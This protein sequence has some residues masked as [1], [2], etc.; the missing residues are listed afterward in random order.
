MT[1]TVANKIVI[2]GFGLMGASL[3]AALKQ[4]G[5]CE[6]I[7]AVARSE[8][9][10]RE[11]VAQG[12]AARA[13][14]SIADVAAELTAGDLICLAVP[15]L[16][17]ADILPQLARLVDDSVTLTDC[18]S[19]KGSVAK[20][21]IAAYGEVPPQFVLGH[22]ICGSEKSGVGAANPNLYTHQ[23]II[24]TPLETTAA[25]H[26]ARVRA[27]WQG[28]DSEVLELSV[29]AHDQVL[30]GTSHLPH[31]IAYSLVDTL[32][33]DPD[34]ENLFRYA[35]GGFKDFTRIA[36][37][38]PKMWHDIMLANRDSILRS[39]DLFSENFAVLRDAIAAG[40]GETLM[41]L[42]KKSKQARD[43]VVA[44]AATKMKAKAKTS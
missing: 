40:D 7:I 38:D 39:M 20:A 28:L 23:R 22:P 13:F 5:M 16:V 9:T 18:S 2:V 8:D 14:Q 32:A 15:T 11:A 6:E 27:M 37:S 25:D 30:A 3:G 19:V 43:Q 35:A 33:S 26:L 17:V 4:R 1:A 21:A 44:T 42:F 34:H 24:L 31:V 41:S 36:S 12:L 29:E 10:C